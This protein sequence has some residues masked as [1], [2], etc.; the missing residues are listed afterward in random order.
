ERGRADR[1]HPW[2]EDVALVEEAVSGERHPGA[3]ERTGAAARA[4]AAGRASTAASEETARGPDAGAG[5]GQQLAGALVP[6]EDRL[7]DA[8]GLRSGSAAARPA[9]RLWTGI[10]HR[11]AAPRR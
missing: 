5:F 3:P 8:F 7:E 6:A 9:P 4:G 11:P 10:A 1:P 2:H